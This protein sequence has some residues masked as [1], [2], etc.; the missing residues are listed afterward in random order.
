MQPPQQH[1]PALLHACVRRH[2]PPAQHLVKQRTRGVR[3]GRG[4]GI[5]SASS[6]RKIRP[7]HVPQI[8]LPLAAKSRSASIYI[9]VASRRRGQVDCGCVS[10][11]L[12]AWS[13]GYRELAH[14]KPRRAYQPPALR[15]QRHGGA[16]AARD[17]EPRASL[18][19][20][21][22]ANLRFQEPW[23]ELS[24]SLSLSA[25]VHMHM[26]KRTT[27]GVP[28]SIAF[29]P[30]LFSNVMC[31]RKL[32][33]RA[34][35]PTVTI[36]ASSVWENGVFDS[37]VPMA[38]SGNSSRTIIGSLPPSSKGATRPWTL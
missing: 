6:A 37:P 24:L 33:C 9:I 4:L 5:P 15:H 22:L 28:T 10:N 8:G 7:A 1:L 26:Y 32:P 16:L 25:A 30:S 27:P 23:S 18:Q 19:L 17:D 12:C 31:S 35:T 34:N 2:R 3:N 11:G 21:R 20:R 13:T 38:H 29:T 36:V 14:S